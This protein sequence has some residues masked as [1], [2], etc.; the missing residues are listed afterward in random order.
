MRDFL[1]LLEYV[2][3]NNNL[4]MAAAKPLVPN[5]V[6]PTII[7]TAP[8]VPNIMFLTIVGLITI[9]PNIMFSTK[10][11]TGKSYRAER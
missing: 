9:M 4:P 5:I 10:P 6:V 8:L 1:N 2:F 7:L 11:L 3:K